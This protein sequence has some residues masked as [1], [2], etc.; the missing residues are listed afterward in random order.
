M[1]DDTR[2]KILNAAGPVFAEKGYQTATVREI[3]RAAGVNV[4]SINYY[5]GDKE[6]LYVE[7]VQRAQQMRT[8]KAPMPVLSRDTPAEERLRSFTR[9]LLKRMIGDAEASWQSQLMMREVLRPTRACQRIAEEYIRPEFELLLS[10]LDDLMPPETPL[11]VRQRLGFSLVGQCLFYRIARPIFEM[12]IPAEERAQ[13]FSIRALTEHI[14]Q[15][16]L[17]SVDSAEAVA[18]E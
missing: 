4:A 16:L 3:C 2:L 18:S 10:I 15:V 7:T 5:F 14:T 1:T 13:E 17:A 6:N 9:T 11:H 8:D 12:L